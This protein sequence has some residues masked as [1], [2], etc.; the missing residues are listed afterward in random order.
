MENIH[1]LHSIPEV[2]EYKILV[3]P[4]NLEV[5]RKIIEDIIHESKISLQNSTNPGKVDG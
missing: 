3:I 2:D 1:I 4:K 5:A